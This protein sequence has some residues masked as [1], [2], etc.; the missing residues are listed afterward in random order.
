MT[1]ESM[2]LTV[3][4]ILWTWI[5]FSNPQVMSIIPPFFKHILFIWYRISLQVN[6][7]PFPPPHSQLRLQSETMVLLTLVSPGLNTAPGTQ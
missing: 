2:E 4:I 1:K 3:G 6:V 5:S 7:F